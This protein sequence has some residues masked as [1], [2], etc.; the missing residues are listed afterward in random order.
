MLS[1]KRGIQNHIYMKSLISL[2]KKYMKRQWKAIY[3][4][5]KN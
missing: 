4:I 5:N 1:E 2:R 3:Q